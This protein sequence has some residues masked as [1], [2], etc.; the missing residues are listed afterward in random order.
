MEPAKGLCAKNAST[1]PNKVGLP[2]GEAF[3][4]GALKKDGLASYTPSNSRTRYQT[5]RK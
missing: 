2:D 3:Y 4:A 1:P 5:M